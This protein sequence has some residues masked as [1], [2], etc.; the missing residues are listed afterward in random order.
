MKF[1]RDGSKKA[2]LYPRPDSPRI[3]SEPMNRK[4]VI[5]IENSKSHLPFLLQRV[6]RMVP[7]KDKDDENL[8][9]LLA[10]RLE[11]DGEAATTEYLMNKIREIIQCRYTGSL[12]DYL[13]DDRHA[14]GC[15]QADPPPEPPDIA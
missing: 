12:Y 9:R 1:L 10:F 2:L 11:I 7:D 3:E 8:K 5:A 15:R 14:A 4:K 13:K 6:M